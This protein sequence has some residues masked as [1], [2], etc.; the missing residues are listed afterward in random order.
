LVAAARFAERFDPTDARTRMLL[1]DI[2]LSQQKPAEAA[3]SLRI[4]LDKNPLD[5]ALGVRWLDLRT[6]LLNTAADRIELLQSV[7]DDESYTPALRGEAAVRR[8][9]ILERQGVKDGALESFGKAMKLD[10]AHPVAIRAA[11]ALEGETSPVREFEILLTLLRSNPLAVTVAWELAQRLETLGFYDES[12]EVF[13]YALALFER[14]GATGGISPQFVVQHFNA[15]LDAGQFTEAVAAFEPVLETFANNPD[16]Q[17]LM[18]EALE[19]L[20]VDERR[21]KLVDKMESR[22]K[23]MRSAGDKRAEAAL[24]WFYVVSK[25]TPDLALL[26]ARKAAEGKDEAIFQRIVGAAQLKGGQ[27]LEGEKRLRKLMRDDLYAAAL[28][29]E[30]YLELGNITA[31]SE[32]IAA[33]AEQSRG[34]P[35]FRR[36]RV[37][38]QKYGVEIPPSANTAA[39]RKVYEAFDERIFEMGL[40]PER[41]LAVSIHPGSQSVRVG[42]P[43]VVE[44]TLA[45]HGPLAMPVGRLGLL[46]PVMGLQVEIASDSSEDV[47]RFDA[48]PLVLWAAPRYLAPATSV[49]RSVR[50]DVGEVAKFLAARPLDKLQLTVKGLLDPVQQGKVFR[51]ALPSLEVKSAQVVR[52][53]LIGE[54]DRSSKE[55]WTAGYQL[56]LGRIVRDIRR[57]DLP[58][59]ISAA[60]KVASLLA[61]TDRVQRGEAKFPEPLRSAVERSVL[62]AMLRTVL[63]DRSFLVRAEMLTALQDVRI[64]ASILMLLGGVIGDESALV[65][66]RAAELLG[67][68]DPVKNKKVLEH[69][70][71]DS[72][73]LVRTVARALQVQRSAR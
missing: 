17:M 60:R 46:S 62:L 39:A 9:A 58:A 5:H 45:N 36:L 6:S 44:A 67:V 1:A 11:A 33:A 56:A 68:S 66:F 27:V 22:W 61:L 21:S 14:Y 20:G 31:A 51:S 32:A 24:A 64:D 7:M 69:L 47:A 40:H 48:L 49:T 53:G 38:A 57:G 52:T 54:S 73:E 37:T 25:P 30:H 70:A 65:R 71:K 34:G 28:L 41:F 18:A 35:G 8:G 23:A 63:S 15:M 19:S 3:D 42:E 13:N 29:A 59:R 43:V 16:L 26:H 4:Y 10:P 50:L 55:S 2:S 72:D 12:V